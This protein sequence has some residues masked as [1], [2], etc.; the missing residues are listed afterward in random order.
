MGSV[1]TFCPKKSK[2][3]YPA[4]IDERVLVP[5]QLAKVG[6]DWPRTGSPEAVKQGACSIWLLRESY[7]DEQTFM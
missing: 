6:V 4:L 3:W 7:S 5:G 2:A 1:N